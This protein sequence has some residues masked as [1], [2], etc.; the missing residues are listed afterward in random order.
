MHLKFCFSINFLLNFKFHWRMQG[1]T[2]AGNL[3]LFLKIYRSELTFCTF[4]VITYH[5]VFNNKMSKIWTCTPIGYTGRAGRGIGI[6]E[7][8]IVGGR[9][10]FNCID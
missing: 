9:G 1:K 3:N 8:V 2:L 5:N 4:F 10:V 7:C 6:E